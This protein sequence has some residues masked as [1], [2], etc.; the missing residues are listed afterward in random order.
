MSGRTYDEH[1]VYKPLKCV[2][3]K[4]DAITETRNSYMYEYEEGPTQRCSNRICLDGGK[5]K[6]FKTPLAKWPDWVTDR[7]SGEDETEEF[8]FCNNCLKK[9]KREVERFGEVAV[10]KVYE[11]EIKHLR[12]YTS[13]IEKKISKLEKEVE[14]CDDKVSEME[15]YVTC[16]RDYNPMDKGLRI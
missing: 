8:I 7:G 10:R 13:D 3:C 4:K 11:K 12:R 6:R 14:N 2:L 5:A 1:T 16:H 9:R 15:L